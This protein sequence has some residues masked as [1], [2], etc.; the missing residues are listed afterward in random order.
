MPDI[1]QFIFS[2]KHYAAVKSKMSL[3]T[4][5]I[6]LCSGCTSLRE[7]SKYE[8]NSGVY[9]LHMR[10][11]PAFDH[12]FDKNKKDWI[13]QHKPWVGLAFGLNLN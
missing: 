7:S 4:F 10:G 1:Y 8:F 13:Y 12:L 3:L 9:K 11:T 2:V 5:F 6:S